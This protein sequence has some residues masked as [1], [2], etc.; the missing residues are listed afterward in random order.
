MSI[1]RE[2]IEPIGNSEA[3]RRELVRLGRSLDSAQSTTLLLDAFRDPYPPVR[4][5]A[6]SLLGEFMAPSIEERVVERLESGEEEER[7]AA[8]IALNSDG[9]SRLGVQ[10]LEAATHDASADVRYHA[11]V[12]L[13]RFDP[14]NVQE[15]VSRLVSDESDPAILVVCAQMIS[16]KG[17]PWL[18]QLVKVR[19]GLK[20]VDRFQLSF[21]LARL[22]GEHHV[23][24]PPELS[25]SVSQD[26]VGHLKDEATSRA[27][28]QGL[29]YLG[30]SKAV[31]PLRKIAKG[32][33]LHPIIRVDAAIAL[34]QLGDEEGS[35]LW[36]KH[37]QGRRKDARGWAIARAGELKVMEFREFVEREAV[38]DTYHSETAL[39]SL[40]HYDDE[41]A[42]RVIETRA[43]ESADTETRELAHQLLRGRTH[44]L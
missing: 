43:R 2:A 10:A 30:A 41:A 15:I 7:T 16:E 37:L 44:A 3:R 29:V 27:A 34:F 23:K 22:R 26:L 42:W 21:S 11:L 38:S 36:Q 40:S 19:E 33:L 8:C 5:A 12:S 6:A 32:W 1:Y 25:E 17:W 28:I 20:G 4:H 14:A 39:I 13:H 35:R 18:E 9:V 24:L 31:E